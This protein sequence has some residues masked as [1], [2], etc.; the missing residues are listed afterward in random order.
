MG[1]ESRLLHSISRWTAEKLNG[2]V[3]VAALADCLSVPRV[4]T[5]RHRSRW[6]CLSPLYEGL[7][8]DLD[9]NIDLHD[10]AERREEGALARVAALHVSYIGHVELVRN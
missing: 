2:I 10:A 5:S 6:V 9:E 8:I 1:N 7:D 3:R 4:D